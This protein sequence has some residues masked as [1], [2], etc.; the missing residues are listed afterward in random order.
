MTNQRETFPGKHYCK[1]ATIQWL[2]FMTHPVLYDVNMINMINGGNIHFCFL[3]CRWNT[4]A[5]IFQLSLSATKQTWEMTRIS[6]GNFSKYNR[7]Q[8]NQNRAARWP[9]RSKLVLIWNAQP[10]QKK[11]SGKSLR[12]Q[13]LQPFKWRGG[14]GRRGANDVHCYNWL[15][16]LVCYFL[17]SAI[18]V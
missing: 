18:L 5:P 13:L 17:Y 10:E 9:K 12:R 4:S 16:K 8:S 14:Q 2:R 1:Q 6:K 3:L 11:V 15:W 7:S